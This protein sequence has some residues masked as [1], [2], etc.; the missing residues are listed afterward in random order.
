MTDKQTNILITIL[1][2]LLPIVSFSA[3]WL[4]ND[5]VETV[6]P[7]LTAGPAD[8]SDDFIVFWEA[9]GHVERTFIGEVPNGRG[10]VY[11]AIRGALGSLNDPYTVFLEPVAREEEQISLRGN[12]G[13]IGAFIGRNDAG[14]VVLTVI[15]GNPAEEAGIQDEDVLLAIDGEP[16]TAEMTSEEIAQMV[17]GEIG[18]EVVLSIRRGEDAEPEDFVVTRGQILIPSVI[19]RLLPEDE[20]IGYIQLTRFSGESAEE[21]QIA[22]E[23]L[24]AE[25][26]DSLILDMRGNSGGLLDA[27]IEIADQFVTDGTILIQESRADGETFYPATQTAVAPDTPMVILIDGG[28]ASAAEIVAGALGDL[29]R[30]TLIG[31]KTFGKGSV[32]LIYDL[33]DGS[34]VHVT[35]ARWYTPKRQE[36]D[37]QGLQPDIEVVPSA[38]AI[39]SGKD[40]ILQNAVEFLTGP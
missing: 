9:W 7:E 39:A 23:E 30:A 19:A 25:G 17:R 21:V 28:T 38:E 1:L 11:S 15:P 13:G 2:I 31:Q 14:E 37:Q 5:Y 24:L 27:A 34:S 29:E 36:I 8:S 4:T 22:T 26:V 16:L 10:L 35:A 32:Q 40:E 6:W 20:T 3:G 18:T 12:F 33:S